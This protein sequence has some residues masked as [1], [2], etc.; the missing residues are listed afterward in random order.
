M[1]YSGRAKVSM[2]QRAASYHMME[3]NDA[4]RPGATDLTAA[5]ACSEGVSNAI[6]RAVA[7]V[8]IATTGRRTAQDLVVMARRRG[9]RLVVVVGGVSRH[10]VHVGEAM[11]E[12]GGGIHGPEVRP[13][14]TPSLRSRKV[15]VRS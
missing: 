15:R 10:H 3:A 4:A 7:L 2:E 11:A 9:R 12:D 14:E 8:V 13:R 5:A 6:G 1:R